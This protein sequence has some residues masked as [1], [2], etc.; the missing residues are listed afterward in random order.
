MPAEKIEV[1]HTE[2]SLRVGGERDV[3]LRFFTL[4]VRIARCYSQQSAISVERQSGN[5]CRVLRV[6]HIDQD[7][8]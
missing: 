2:M 4:L 7:A 3:F 5:A 8:A 6:L 1:K